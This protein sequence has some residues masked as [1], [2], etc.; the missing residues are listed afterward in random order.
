MEGGKRPFGYDEVGE[1]FD[2][3]TCKQ[4]TA[5]SMSTAVVSS[6]A[7]QLYDADMI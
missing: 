5:V 2:V 7:V 3:D 6:S 4:Q 1:I